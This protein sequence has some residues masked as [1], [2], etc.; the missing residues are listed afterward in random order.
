MEILLTA[1]FPAFAL[2]AIG[3]G[4]VRLKILGP[5]LFPALNSF[6]YYVAMPALLI[7]SLAG[8][9][10]TEIINWN[11]IAAFSIGSAIT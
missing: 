8:V 3:Y 11:F 5:A 7:A 10:V 1:V 9:L 4:S 6:V 2:I